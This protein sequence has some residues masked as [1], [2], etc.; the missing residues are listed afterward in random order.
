MSPNGTRARTSRTV[1]YRGVSGTFVRGPRTKRAPTPRGTVKNVGHTTERQR[2]DR[3]PPSLPPAT[4]EHPHQRSGGSNQAR[5]T[6]GRGLLQHRFRY[7]EVRV[8]GLDVVVVVER[9]DQPDQGSGLGLRRD[10][11][12][13]VRL[14]RQVGGADLDPGL[15]ERGADGGQRRG[16]GRHLEQ[17][18]VL[19]DVVGAGVDRRDQVVLVVALAI[20][21]DDALLL[22]LPG[23]RARLAEAPAGLV[24]CVAD[25]GAGAIAVVGERIDQDRGAAGAVALID[26]PLDLLVAQ[27]APVPRSIARWML[28][29]GIE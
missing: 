24:E 8:Y 15:L 10:L 25:L 18:A 7:V 17:V 3:P 19:A 11:D 5:A 21:D 2:A 28:S 1:P 27:P 9:L 16:L 14:H 13:R 22:E 4:V 29:L 12:D 20:D 26:D 23:D 6:L